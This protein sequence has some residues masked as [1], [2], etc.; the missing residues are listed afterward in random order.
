MN[1][2]FL[3]IVIPCY[4][5]SE[6]LKRGVLQ[7]VEK[8]LQTQDFG[9]EVII[10]DDESSDNS[11]DLVER[12][13]VGKPNFY[14]DKIIHSGKP[15]AVRK[16]I[17]MARGEWVLFTDM[18]QATPLNQLERLKPF[19]KEYDTV[20]GSRG[21]ARKNF[22]I[23]RRLASVV[24]VNFRRLILLRQIAD[25]QCGFKAFKKAAALKIFPRLQVFQART[26]AFGW[27]VSAYDVE[28]LFIADKEKLKIKE[29]AV[30]WADND[31]TKGKQR[32]FV[33]ESWQMLKEIWRVKINDIKGVYETKGQN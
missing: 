12:F 23:Y 25:T 17:E 13:I 26:K 2:I 29:V 33:K 9:W 11:W 3:S 6:N 7:Q 4:N 20:I 22:P 28:L 19:F 31:I 8:Y 32:S 30:E 15:F 5:E 14:H 24:F 21:M 16:G 1:K 10:V 27:R 18:D